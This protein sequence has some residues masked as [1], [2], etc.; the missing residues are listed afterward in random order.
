MLGPEGLE[1]VIDCYVPEKYESSMPETVEDDPKEEPVRNRQKSF[2]SLLSRRGTD[3][4]MGHCS[5]VSEVLDDETD[6][7]QERK[8]E[9]LLGNGDISLNV[10]RLVLESRKQ[11]MSSATAMNF[12]GSNRRK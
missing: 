8:E 9:Q 7:S 2:K 5:R 11:V 3:N 4:Q 10:N 12:G 1:S 6:L